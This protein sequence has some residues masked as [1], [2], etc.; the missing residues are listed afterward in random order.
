M[1][2]KIGTNI[3]L[4]SMEIATGKVTGVRQ[5]RHRHQEFLTFLRQLARA[6]PNVELHL[7]M[8][9]Y[10]AHKHP[11]VKAWLAANPRIWVHFTPTSASWLNL[12]EV[13]FSI[14]E[15]QAIHRGSFPSVRDLMIKIRAFINGWNN[16]S[17]P[18]VWTKTADQVLDKVKR[19]KNSL[20]PH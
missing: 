14:I 13:W 19:K 6:Y 9:S 16:R 20:T 17:H 18:F 2:P 7:V 5:P 8:D 11:K 3:I 10:A 1:A 4:R 12:V 15:K